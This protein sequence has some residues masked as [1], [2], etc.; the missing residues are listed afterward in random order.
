MEVLRSGEFN[1]AAKDNLS[2]MGAWAAAF[3]RRLSGLR[4][5]TIELEF[6]HE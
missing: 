4:A 6:S 5:S 3:G 2:A 1:Q